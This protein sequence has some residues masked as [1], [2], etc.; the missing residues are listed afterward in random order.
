MARS[1]EVAAD[2]SAGIV[3]P[4]SA[5]PAW[6]ATCSSVASPTV[7]A[8]VPPFTVFTRVPPEILRFVG[9]WAGSRCRRGI[10]APRGSRS[11]SGRHCPRENGSR[12]RLVPQCS[13]FSWPHAVPS[14]TTG[15][16]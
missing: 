13:P 3:H 2:P 12:D 11:P 10:L 4:R 9:G 7:V 5:A 6:R 15:S 14:A 1:R 8:S 16:R